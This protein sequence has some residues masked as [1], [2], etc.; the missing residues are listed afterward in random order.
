MKENDENLLKVIAGVVDPL[1]ESV[2]ELERA[3]TKIHKNLT[4]YH[5][6]CLASHCLRNLGMHRE[7]DNHMNRAATVHHEAAKLA[8]SQGIETSEFHRLSDRIKE[9]VHVNSTDPNA[10]NDSSMT[11][12]TGSN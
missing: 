12:F 3:H 9:N 2:L 11:K 4:D 5:H 10:V 8:K 1:D 7:A 6:H